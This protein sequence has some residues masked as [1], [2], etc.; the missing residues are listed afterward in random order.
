MEGATRSDQTV[1]IM[2]GMDWGGVPREMLVVYMK[3]CGDW[4]ALLVPL[5][6]ALRS[7]GLAINVSE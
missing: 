1:S 3:V 6:K 7:T 5:F 4:T 2:A